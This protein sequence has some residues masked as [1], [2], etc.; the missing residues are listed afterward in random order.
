MRSFEKI[1]RT[2][3]L[4]IAAASLLITAC[5]I[6]PNTADHTTQ[7]IHVQADPV[8]LFQAVEKDRCAVE[9]VGSAVLP[10]PLRFPGA[11]SESDPQVYSCSVEVP[12]REFRAKLSICF[13]SGHNISAGY[14]F[15][16]GDPKTRR[17]GCTA[18][19]LANGNYYFNATGI[20]QDS[21]D[22]VCLPK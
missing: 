2:I 18:H 20:D 3:S 14:S 12:L 21:C 5:T 11:V 4:T 22:W 17:H 10:N 1:M 9:E 13:L 8:Y 16:S 6:L 19:P 7:T 15:F